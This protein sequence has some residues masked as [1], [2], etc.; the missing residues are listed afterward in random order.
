MATMVPREWRDTNDSR[1]EGLIY[2]KLR[3]ETPEDWF[4]VHSVGLTSHRT[5]PT[6]EADFVVIGPFGILCLEVKGGNVTVEHGR[7]FT[8]DSALDENPF[9][10]AGGESAALYAQLGG[11]SSLKRAI[12]GHG[13]LFP[14]TRFD[15]DGP[16]IDRTI[17]YDERDLTTPIRVYLERV[18]D[19]WLTF[20]GRTGDRFR[21][22]SRS[23]RT[24]LLNTVA[25]S[26]TLTP[27][28]RAR[29]TT[30]EAE[31]VELTRE[32]AR[33]FRGIQS[34]DRA[35]VRGGAGTGKTLL[36]VEEAARLARDGRRVLICVRSRNLARYVG[37]CLEERSVDVTWYEELLAGLVREAGLEPQLPDA[38]P[39][40]LLAVFLPELALEAILALDRENSY[41]ALV[42]DEAQDLLVEG[43]LEVWELLL[44][45][46]LTEGIWRVFLDH[47]QNVFSAVDNTQ[48]R[49][50]T[51]AA[52]TRFTLVDNCRNTPQISE[53]T[54]MLSAVDPDTTRAGEGPGVELRFVLDRREDTRAAASV[55]S[56]WIRR[57]V[58]PHD[59]VVAATDGG[60]LERL[61]SAWPA[62]GPSLEPFD[63]PSADSVR[64]VEA[65]DFKGLE[66]AAVVVVG[67]RELHELDTLRRMYVA[68]SRARV[69]LA[70]VI[71]ERARD[72]FNVRAAEYAQRTI[73]GR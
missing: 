49:R 43:A 42:V 26:F 44:G 32:Q 8:N 14:E 33:I 55:V 28:L 25:P 15:R 4:A 64:I 22:L 72:D 50:L 60:T 48:L 47:K 24:A 6:A 19:K 63:A 3:A 21:P 35:L 40:D 7:W 12:V 65:A 51:D 73:A 56:A 53:T 45:G 23:E 68:C 71:D 13:V 16:D 46:G 66:A 59:I 30:T 20:H 34:E 17:V 52:T 69:L 31:L 61:R 11:V 36:A 27:S 9:R 37:D 2:A 38:D 67:V 62:T 5:K 54:C 70:V 29:I 10:Q 41:D 57:G 18:A 39:E 1:A 58:E